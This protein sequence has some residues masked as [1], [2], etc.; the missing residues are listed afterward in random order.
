MKIA[1]YVRLSI[2]FVGL[3][4]VLMVGGCASQ[5]D[6]SEV[7]ANLPTPSTWLGESTWQFHIVDTNGDWIGSIDLALFSESSET[8]TSGDWKYAEV[9]RSTA[10]SIGVGHEIAYEIQGARI[11]IDLHANICDANTMLQGVLVETGAVGKVYLSTLIATDDGELGSFTAAPLIT[12]NEIE[13][14]FD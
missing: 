12:R 1:N 8:C 9:L 14:G 6:Q 3:I 11:W 5:R 7:P 2:A 13:T 10:G 4:Y